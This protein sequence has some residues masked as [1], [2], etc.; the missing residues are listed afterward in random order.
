MLP[1][2]SFLWNS[3]NGK[4][5]IR[6]VNSRIDPSNLLQELKVM[7]YNTITLFAIG[8]D[9]FSVLGDYLYRNGSWWLFF[10]FSGFLVFFF[11]FSFFFFFFLFADLKVPARLL[12]ELYDT[13]S[14]YQLIVSITKVEVRKSEKPLLSETVSDFFNQFCKQYGNINKEPIQESNL[15]KFGHL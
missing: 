7:F 2:T 1:N 8:V 12:P 14:N 4:G 5:C 10:F 6:E 3:I 9:L 11:F 13:R 15:N